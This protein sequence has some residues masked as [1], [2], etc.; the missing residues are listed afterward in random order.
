MP[1]SPLRL[2]RSFTK[3]SK[4]TVLM[5][6]AAGSRGI[7]TGP[8]GIA[9]AAAGLID[10]ERVAVVGGVHGS[11]APSPG[12]SRSRMA[13][14]ATPSGTGRFCRIT[15]SGPSARLTMARASRELGAMNCL[16]VISWLR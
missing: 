9:A 3:R 5:G 6:A 13:V 4:L 12:R 16:A 8:A 10:G 7:A 14:I 2:R 1:D 15:A 11:V